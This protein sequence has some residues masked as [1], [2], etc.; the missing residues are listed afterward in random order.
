MTRA[1]A[2]QVKRRELT[3]EELKHWISVAAYYIHLNTGRADEFLNWLAAESIILTG[4]SLAFTDAALSAALS[5]G[6]DVVDALAARAKSWNDSVNSWAPSS[7]PSDGDE[8]NSGPS[9]HDIAVTTAVVNGLI[10]ARA[11]LEAA[12]VTSA[13]LHGS[14]FP[15]GSLHWELL[16][17]AAV[18]AYASAWNVT[19]PVAAP[20]HAS[21]DKRTVSALSLHSFLS[22]LPGAVPDED[23]GRVHAFHNS[24]LGTH[25][26]H[27]NPT[28]W[29]S[30]D[31]L[32][33]DM[34]SPPTPSSSVQSAAV[35]LATAAK[36]VGAG[37]STASHPGTVWLAASTLHAD[38]AP[39]AK[40]HIGALC[41][42]ATLARAHVD[43]VLVRV[44]AL[45][46]Q[47][48]PGSPR[49]PL[50]VIT[51]SMPP[52][53]STPLYPCSLQ[54]FK[55]LSLSN[56]PLEGAP[57]TS[58]QVRAALAVL[59]E[60]R[61]A[62]L[63][64]SAASASAVGAAPSVSLSGDLWMT[65][66]SVCAVA[67]AFSP[68]F[69]ARQTL[70][71]LLTPPE[72]ALR[73]TVTWVGQV[74]AAVRKNGA[75]AWTT[76][77]D[78]TPIWGSASSAEPSFTVRTRPGFTYGTI[79]PREAVELLVELTVWGMTQCQSLLNTTAA[80]APTVPSFSSIAPSNSDPS[81]GTALLGTMDALIR[82][83][84]K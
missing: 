33:K 61:V 51:V 64:L 44:A 67:K 6:A 14:S 31:D 21:I 43:H 36:A 11:A 7:N 4:N 10:Q 26:G 35:F 22:W 65:L 12:A 37:G 30:V 83:S 48:A 28:A 25:R 40:T 62:Q 71:A 58:Q 46:V 23:P 19:V 79:W 49:N 66:T 76:Q 57:E 73:D 20:E 77:F 68:D 74:E 75:A 42:L 32:V 13:A 16:W 2:L 55:G 78:C 5:S 84:N 18:T 82:S 27:W 39:G 15:P 56:T 34:A 54:S 17:R 3:A 24:I 52:S 69:P 81:Q 29:P 45:D 38:H 8:N 80:N 9:A 53:P 63:A 1:Q 60:L 47:F 70:G 59:A 50:G 72:G 41:N